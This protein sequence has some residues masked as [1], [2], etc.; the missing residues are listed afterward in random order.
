MIYGRQWMKFDFD[1]INAIHHRCR[2][3]RSKS[4]CCCAS[5]DIFI[6]E[7]EMQRILN[8]FPLV[9]EYCPGLMVD[10]EFDN[11]FEESDDGLIRVD[12]DENGLCV[13]AYRF[14]GIIR[15]ALH[16][17]ANDT[18]TPVENVKPFHCLLWPMAVSSGP[19]TVVSIQENALDF[20]CNRPQQS[21]FICKSLAETLQ[22]LFKWNL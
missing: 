17:V 10:G 20:P 18:G 22:V 9:I 7:A 16:T 6:S 21:D 19:E 14:E 13:F 8:I 2:G 11:V 1:T 15:C 4:D 3:C 12:T 5:Y